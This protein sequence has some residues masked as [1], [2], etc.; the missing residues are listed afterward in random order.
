MINFSDY[1]YFYNFMFFIFKP[2][3]LFK[4]VEK[5]VMMI[6]MHRLYII[7]EKTHYI[8]SHYVFLSTI[9]YDITTFINILTFMCQKMVVKKV[10][11]ISHKWCKWLHFALNSCCGHYDEN[12][13]KCEFDIK[14]LF[15]GFIKLLLWCEF[16]NII[17]IFRTLE[18]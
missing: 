10:L 18:L 8:F 11:Y 7:L 14:I 9:K 3:K 6:F 15:T 13:R 5:A 4:R 1:Q 2:S 12:N 17:D 16:F